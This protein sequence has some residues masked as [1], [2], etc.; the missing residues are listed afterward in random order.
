MNASIA[1][2]LSM[3]A[4]LEEMTPGLGGEGAPAQPPPTLAH[5]TKLVARRNTL[6]L[7]QLHEVQQR[8]FQDEEARSVRLDTKAAA[9]IGVNA[10][11]LTLVSSI[12]IGGL[13]RA[14]SKLTLLAIP[15]YLVSVALGLYTGWLALEAVK[16]ADFNKLKESD[17]FHEDTLQKADNVIDEDDDGNMK[18]EDRGLAL[19][20]R[21]NIVCLGNLLDKDGPV[22]DRKAAHLEN[23]QKAFQRFLVSVG[24]LA[25]A[26][27]LIAIARAVF[28]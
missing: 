21:Y 5:L 2:W 10:V 3:A 28:A 24:V 18:F 26:S 25:L 16:V 22:N 6:V 4:E 7:K 23:A 9:L 15:F 19:Y 14:D 11:T 20:H 17:V 13:L 27:A 12:G 1:R 8:R